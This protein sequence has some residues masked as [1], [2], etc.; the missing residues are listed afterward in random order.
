[1][2]IK[3]ETAALRFAVHGGLVVFVEYSV[4]ALTSVVKNES[5][6]SLVTS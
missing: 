6:Y 4:I 5:S 1:M 3:L 2:H